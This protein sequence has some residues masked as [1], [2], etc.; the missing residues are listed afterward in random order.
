M[1]E[2]TLHQARFPEGRGLANH[3]PDLWCTYAA[4]RSLAW[5]ERLGSIDV[6]QLRAYI[7]S[8]RNR[9]GG[10]AWSKG[11]SSDAWATFYCTE[12]LKDLETSIDRTDETAEWI[13][14]LFDGDAYAM[15]PGQTADAWATHYALRTLIEVCQSQV[16]DTDALYAWL[17]RL[18]CANGGLSW[19]ADFARRDLADTRACFYG[20]MAARA[21][22]RSG[23]RGPAWDRPRLIAWLQAQQM[24]QGGFRFSESAQSPCLWATYRATASLAELKAQPLERSRCIEW[25]EALRTCS[26][27]FVRWDGYDGEDVWAVFCAVGSLKALGESV[28]HLADDAAEFISTLAMPQGGY[29]YRNTADAADVLSTA[30]GVLG[31]TLASSERESAIRW[32]EGCQMPNE[33]GV[34]YMP[35]R[36]AEVRCTLWA[37]AAGAFADE[38]RSRRAIGR[39]LASLQNPDGGFGFWEGRGSDIVSTASAVSILQRLGDS[40]GVDLGSVERFVASCQRGD[41]DQLAYAAYPRG[42]V[43]LRAGLQALGCLAYVGHDVK[44]E[45]ARLLSSHKVR[46]GGFANRGQRIPDLLSTYQAVTLAFALDLPVDEEHLRYFL[47]KVETKQGFAWSPLYLEGQDALSACLGRLLQAFVNGVLKQLPNLHLS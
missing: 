3:Q 23:L 25:I 29:T 46:Q 35:G 22:Q 34:M 5:L 21:L 7:Q 32:I 9:D 42:Q 6:A 38:P 36:G 44:H 40:S 13:H 47:E 2:R 14:T 20:V 12:T 26:G 27:A 43:S 30:A 19:S 24:D 11:M 31:G 4:I 17:E 39:W 41:G 18:Q 33:A 16:Q 37:L 10:Y 28:E 45:A 15:C 1:S 8:R